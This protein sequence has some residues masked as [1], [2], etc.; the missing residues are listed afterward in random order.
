MK[1]DQWSSDH[2][3]PEEVDYYATLGVNPNSSP[4]EIQKA[5]RKLAS[6]FHPDRFHDSNQK[7]EASRRFKQVTD[8]YTVLNDPMKRKLYDQFGSSI[9]SR[10]TALQLAKRPQCNESWM[11]NVIRYQRR[12]KLA[13]LQQRV[14]LVGSATA[15]IDVSRS[16]R[17]PRLETMS[18]KQ[19]YWYP[20]QDHQTFL[21]IMV[22]KIIQKDK[23]KGDIH[24]SI[25][26]MVLN[27][28]MVKA[29]VNMA[30]N[31]LAWKLS[32]C[33][34]GFANTVQKL[35][36]SGDERGCSLSTGVD[37]YLSDHWTGSINIT[38]G[39]S[40][41][42][43]AEL[44]RTGKSRQE[45]ESKAKLNE[46]SWDTS[47]SCR[48]KRN[49]V[50]LS[51]RSTRHINERSMIAFE[52]S[53]SNSVVQSSS[54]SG[55]SQRLM[56][57]QTWHL[58]AH[59]ERTVSQLS[60]LHLGFTIAPH[61]VYMSLGFSRFGQTLSLPIAISPI[62]TLYSCFTAMSLPLLLAFLAQ[63]LWLEPRRAKK[64][65]KREETERLK[66]QK[67]IQL[68]REQAKIDLDLIQ[69]EIDRKKE[70]EKKKGGLVILQAF[71]GQLKNV[72]QTFFYDQ[73]PLYDLDQPPE[74]TA[75]PT[76]D[77]DVKKEC[78]IDVTDALQYM[79]YHSQLKISPECNKASFLGFYD[80]CPGEE[81]WIEIVY[82]YKNEVH[83]AFLSDLEAVRLP[84]KSHKIVIE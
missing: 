83:R 2:E 6:S 16:L 42:L 62:P 65:K 43:K 46:F 56:M 50:S 5:F 55:L 67:Q 24:L 11:D 38:S 66:K 20:F 7:Q 26:H 44:V 15:M 29:G 59:Y 68:S 48:L 22:Q 79:V 1:S 28:L 14:N 17:N 40:P 23:G 51:T 71:Y 52:A 18:M 49:Q 37:V 34:S 82:L 53:T 69:R 77:T 60:K 41:M 63:A 36:L 72:D 8:A 9:L 54:F 74:Y 73:L 47:I 45:Q 70:E 75:P 35:S 39:K 12:Q 10:M 30:W 57:I 76:T 58:V 61:G 31:Q 27:S 64:K 33:H 32:A 81:K 21:T 13:Y 78:I 84:L 80:P 25:S 3:N 19:T 4:S